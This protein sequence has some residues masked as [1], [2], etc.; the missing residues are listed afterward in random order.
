[1]VILTLATSVTRLVSDIRSASVIHSECSDHKA[2]DLKPSNINGFEGA[3]A[4]FLFFL[5]L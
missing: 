3:S 5:E 2:L 1:M 4:P